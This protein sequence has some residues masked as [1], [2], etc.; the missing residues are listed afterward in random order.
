MYKFSGDQIVKD[1]QQFFVDIEHSNMHCGGAILN[2]VLNYQAAKYLSFYTGL[3]ARAYL[4]GVS[5]N[6]AEFLPASRRVQD[7]LTLNFSLDL[8][9]SFTF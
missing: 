8:G 2:G 4:L 6:G 9:L 7:G 3:N 1:S 5:E